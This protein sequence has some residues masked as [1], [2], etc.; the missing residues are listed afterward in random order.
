MGEQYRAKIEFPGHA[1]WTAASQ[2]EMNQW[3]SRPDVSPL[4]VRVLFAAMSRCD[5]SGHAPFKA[6]ELARILG[7][8]TV[9][10][11]GDLMPAG[12]GTVRNAIRAAKRL[13][14]VLP[15]SM[16]R[17]LVLNPDVFQRGSGALTKCVHD[18]G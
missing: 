5:P 16:A 13:G 4:A 12:K 18:L 3:A 2:Y 17:C 9:N 10:A 6:G 7:D 1:H 8:G 11:K 15:E 14:Y